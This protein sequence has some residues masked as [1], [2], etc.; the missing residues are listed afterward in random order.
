MSEKPTYV[1]LEFELQAARAHLAYMKQSRDSWRRAEYAADEQMRKM[2][3]EAS[4][5]RGSLATAQ[6]ANID[7]GRELA[8]VYAARAGLRLRFN[9]LVS[10]TT[11]LE[12]ELLD[13]RQEVS[14]MKMANKALVDGYDLVRKERDELRTERDTL[15]DRVYWLARRLEDAWRVAK[16]WDGPVAESEDDQS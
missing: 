6:K 13:L 2:R 4:A 3:Q 16:Q 14:D 1:Q 11:T 10:R 7:I 12:T 9:R 15:R 5:L 8:D